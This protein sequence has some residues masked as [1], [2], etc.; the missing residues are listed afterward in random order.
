M[1]QDPAGRAVLIGGV[2]L[3]T[4][5]LAITAATVWLFLRRADHPTHPV[6]LW[7]GGTLTVLGGIV[8][9]VLIFQTVASL[10]GKRQRDYEDYLA[11]LRAD[12]QRRAASQPHPADAASPDE[13]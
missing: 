1:A 2:T 12:E 5:W 4:I 13:P 6:W 7:T 9:A 11:G 10:G 3:L 8:L